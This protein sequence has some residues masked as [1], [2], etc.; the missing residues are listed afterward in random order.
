MVA[1]QKEGWE[2]PGRETRS[3]NTINRAVFR[4]PPLVWRLAVDSIVG[5]LCLNQRWRV[6][7]QSLIVRVKTRTTLQESHN[8][9]AASSRRSDDGF[10]N[11]N[12]QISRLWSFS[13]MINTSYP[14]YPEY[15]EMV[16]PP[17]ICSSARQSLRPEHDLRWPE[18]V[19]LD[20][21]RKHLRWYKYGGRNDKFLLNQ[22]SLLCTFTSPP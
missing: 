1:L 9:G 19:S 17:H 3:A 5:G 13:E 21:E 14:V 12:S 18:R 6:W 15:F 8:E 2:A 4:R 16:A 7:N 11:I 10:L 22:Q 20:T